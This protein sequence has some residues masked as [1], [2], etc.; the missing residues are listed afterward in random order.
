MPP[1]RGWRPLLD[2]GLDLPV[3]AASVMNFYSFLSA[4]TSLLHEYDKV[5]Q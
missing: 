4:D 1:A 2:D 5:L 3:F